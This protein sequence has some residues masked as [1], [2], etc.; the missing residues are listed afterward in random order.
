M[1]TKKEEHMLLHEYDNLS[2]DLRTFWTLRATILGAG[3]TIMFFLITN[4]LKT[5]SLSRFIVDIVLLFFIFV[6]EKMLGA[7]TRS[8]YLFTYRMSEISE[9]LNV[10][11]FWNIWPRYIK[12]CPG[13]T[14]SE[15]FVVIT[16]FLN[17]AIGVF[18]IIEK[19]VAIIGFISS[20]NLKSD[21]L[22][23][24]E[25]VFPGIFCFFVLLYL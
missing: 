15:A 13:T 25:F 18:I 22:I 11:G 16:K 20:N 7:F 5:K 21:K 17:I 10:I 4:T 12:R 14:G 19:I 23:M 2:N 8:Q 6:L 9:K 24:W 3:I 1:N